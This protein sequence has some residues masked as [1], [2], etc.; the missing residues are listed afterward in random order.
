MGVG[1][2]GEGQHPQQDWQQAF[3]HEGASDTAMARQRCQQEEEDE[4]L[5]L[6]QDPQERGSTAQI[7]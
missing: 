7:E 3:L 5:G 1:E 2:G 6:I 4:L